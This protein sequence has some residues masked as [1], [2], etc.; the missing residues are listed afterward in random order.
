MIRSC[1]TCGLLSLGGDAFPGRCKW[2]AKNGK[3]KE[4]RDIPTSKIDKGCGFWQE[5]RWDPPK[6]KKEGK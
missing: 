1:W 6:K 5:E 3:G 2:F 4:Y